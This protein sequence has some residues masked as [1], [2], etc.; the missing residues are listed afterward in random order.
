MRIAI[1]ADEGVKGPFHMGDACAYNRIAL[2]DICLRR[3]RVSLI[4]FGKG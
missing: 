4:G 3:G 1:A 2:K